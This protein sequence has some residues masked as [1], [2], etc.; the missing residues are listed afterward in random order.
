MAEVHFLI[1]FTVMVRR[2][3][4]DAA[5][6]VDVSAP[7]G[8]DFDLSIRFR[9]LGKKLLINPSAFI[10]HHAFKTGERVRGGPD[11]SGGWNSIEMRDRTNKWLIQ[12]HGFKNTWRL[13]PVPLFLMPTGLGRV[14]Q[15]AML[16]VR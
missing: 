13:F 6:G 4:L 5:G 12:K 7:G 14:I 9:N 1:F 2:S 15:K 3:D 8:D 16:F 11:T 10:I